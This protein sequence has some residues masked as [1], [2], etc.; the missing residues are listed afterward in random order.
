MTD[1]SSTSAGNPFDGRRVLVTGAAGFIGSHLCAAL[2]AR[3]ARVIGVD[4]F[5]SGTRD[6]VAALTGAAGFELL[7]RD[8]A[9]PLDVEA[10]LI[11][12]LAC[13]A[14]PVD[15]QRHPVE[16]I[17]ASVLGAMNLLEL[18]R[19]QGAVIVQASTSEIYGDPREHP[20]HESYW[21]HVNPVGA[22]ACYNESKRCAETMF[23]TWRSQYGIDARIARLFNVYGPRM[24]AN[25]GRVVSNFIVQALHGQDI[26]VYGDGSQTRSFCFVDDIVDGLLRLAAAGSDAWGPVNLGNPQEITVAALARRIVALCGSRSALRFMPLP[27][28]DPVR[29]CPNIAV[30]RATLAWQPQI[31]L[32]QGLSATIA[33]FQQQAGTAR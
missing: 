28:D 5:L 25:D 29:R 2:L 20:Q 24:R 26:T 17:K 13:P 32:D 1:P 23:A 15:Y 33:W 30:A 18:A 7:E 14:S 22:R 12:N 4:N 21:G 27:A 8:I 19:R 16:T 11:I 10:G 3:G 9:E 6:N 31:D